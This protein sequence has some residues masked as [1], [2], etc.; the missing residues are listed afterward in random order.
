MNR[1]EADAVIE[2]KRIILSVRKNI[3]I[4]L[5]ESTIDDYSWLGVYAL[6]LDEAV[7]M[8]DEAMK[9]NGDS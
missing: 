9:E 3:G 7:A 8:I 1:K 2:A 4:I 6:S 5:T